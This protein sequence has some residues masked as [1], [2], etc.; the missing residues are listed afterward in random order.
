MRSANRKTLHLEIITPEQMVFSGKVSMVTA[1]GT[2]GIIGI[3][4]NH[5]PLFSRLEPGELKI[6]REGRKTSYMALA[7][8][9]IQVQLNSVT[10]LADTAERAESI[11]EAKAIEAKKRAESLLSK[12][13]S[14][15]EFI[16]AEAALRKSLADLKVVKRRRKRRTF[17]A[18]PT[19]A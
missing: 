5:I 2:E 13:L 19:P 8:G 4:P 18:T 7:G 6:V 10:I 1:P 15:V 9:F 3:L 12:K 17:S 16:K 11:N 14:N